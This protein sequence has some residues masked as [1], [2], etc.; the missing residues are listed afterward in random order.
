MMS[1]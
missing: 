1:R